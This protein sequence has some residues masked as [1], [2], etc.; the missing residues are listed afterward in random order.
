M[1][2]RTL[3]I[4]LL[5]AAPLVSMIAFGS[6]LGE[7]GRRVRPEQHAALVIEPEPIEPDP[8]E[9]DADVLILDVDGSAPPDAQR[10]TD[11]SIPVQ[12]EPEVIPPSIEDVERMCVLVT[13]CADLPPTIVSDTV[14]GC[15]RRV[16]NTFA[17]AKALNWN[18]VS[19]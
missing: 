7:S 19:R 9:Y 15:V 13:S 5:I 17:S 2:R 8:I 6:A 1:R 12:Y 11:S 3:A 14:P 10:P 16:M 4:V 18:P